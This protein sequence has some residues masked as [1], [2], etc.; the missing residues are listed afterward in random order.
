[1]SFLGH[2]QA[3]KS[4]P[5]VISKSVMAGI[6]LTVFFADDQHGSETV[7]P[8]CSVQ[9]FSVGGEIRSM[10]RE[11]MTWETGPRRK[12]GIQEYRI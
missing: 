4:K 6:T 5:P 12:G 7:G 2:D 3:A 1:M 9:P 10:L 11:Q 8:P